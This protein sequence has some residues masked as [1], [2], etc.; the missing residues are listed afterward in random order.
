[1]NLDYVNTLLSFIFTMKLTNKI[2]QTTG[3]QGIVAL[4]I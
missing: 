2:K 1:M 4:L 3:R